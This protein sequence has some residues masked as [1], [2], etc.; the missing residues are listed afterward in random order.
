MSEI[1]GEILSE[2]LSEIL[3]ENVLVLVFVKS[4]DKSVTRCGV[5]TTQFFDSWSFGSSDEGD[6]TRV[7]D[8]LG[9]CFCI[10]P[11]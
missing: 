1:L 3:G 4:A 5:D 7:E 8:S 2:I 10:Q 6:K 9:K 11:F